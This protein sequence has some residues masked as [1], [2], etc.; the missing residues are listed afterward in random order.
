VPLRIVPTPIG[1]LQ[2]ITLRAIEVLKNAHLIIAED[3]R[4]S[5]VLLNHYNI[6]TPLQSYHMHNEHTIVEKYITQLIAGQEIALISDAGT[7][8]ISDPGYLLIRE[9]IKNNIVVDCL[10]GATAFTPALVAS[11]I[12]CD[13][14]LYQGFL[15]Q[16]KGRQTAL[17]HLATVRDTIV[18]YES[19]HR[20]AKTLPELVLYF[21]AERQACVCREISKKFEEY[22]RGSLQE[23]ATHYVTA[24]VRGEIVLVIAG[25]EEKVKKEKARK[26][27]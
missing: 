15:P 26:G 17:L 12:P 16:K 22:K 9:A 7:P 14:F 3:T 25:N 6:T 4:T 5:K 20:L 2:D 11:G 8:G 19:P 13:T 1:N 23:L 21:G 10:P 18:F 27:E 24:T